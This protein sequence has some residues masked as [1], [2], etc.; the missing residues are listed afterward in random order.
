[1][2]PMEQGD[3]FGGALTVPQASQAGTVTVPAIEEWLQGRPEWLEGYLF[4]RSKGVRYRDAMLAVWLSLSKDDRGEVATRD[5]FAKI[6]GVSRASTYEWETKRPEIRQW[7]E[8][9]QVQRLRGMRLA[10]VDEAAYQAAISEKGTASDRQ[11]YYKRAGV[12][13]D[14]VGVR[15]VDPDDEP[16]GMVDV[17]DEE[18]EAIRAA[19]ACAVESGSEAG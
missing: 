18:F 13:E 3:L 12:W 14:R 7:A 1:M 17:T 8:F 4:L 6:M 9:L 16:V 10:E 15:P 2:I 5:E 11:L 19:L